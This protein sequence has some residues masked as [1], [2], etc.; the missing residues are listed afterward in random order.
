MMDDDFFSPKE[1]GL[2]PLDCLGC[3]W[4]CLDTPC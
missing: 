2:P 1:P 3:G 4:C